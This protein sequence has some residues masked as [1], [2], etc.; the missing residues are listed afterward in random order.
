MWNRCLSGTTREHIT[1]FHKI[2][3]WVSY[4]LL[5][6]PCQFWLDSDSNNGHLVVK[7]YSH[8]WAHLKLNSRRTRQTYEYKISRTQVVDK[9]KTKVCA[10]HMC[11]FYRLEGNGPEFLCCAYVFCLLKFTIACLHVSV[12]QCICCDVISPVQGCTNSGRQVVGETN[13]C[14]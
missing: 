7:T 6:D 10:H 11:G 5:K 1:D 3:Y 8:F 4:R 13:F 2:C 9:N 12:E 14:T